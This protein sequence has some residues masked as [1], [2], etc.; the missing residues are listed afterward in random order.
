V[1][2]ENFLI[3]NSSNRQAVEAIGE[4]FPKLDVIAAFAFI[5]KSVYSIDTST[6]V[7]TPENKKVFRI[8]D[9]IGE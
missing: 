1:H 8:F 2:A 4:S 6:L 3:Y 7:V 5:I 9:F